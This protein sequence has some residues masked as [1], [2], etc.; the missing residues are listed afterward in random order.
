M[1]CWWA[2]LQ[3]CRKALYGSTR[4]GGAH[5][6]AGAFPL[7]SV[8][9]RMPPEQLSPA[10]GG[11]GSHHPTVLCVCGGRGCPEWLAAQTGGE[12]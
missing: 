5:G 9:V 7:V 10:Q 8:V 3:K 1:R 6:K 2:L 4:L 11:R 12:Q